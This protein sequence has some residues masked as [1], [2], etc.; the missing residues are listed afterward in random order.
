MKVYFAT[1]LVDETLGRSLTKKRANT[2]LVSYH[3][4]K[5][6]KVTDEELIQYVKIG[7]VSRKKQRDEKSC[8]QKK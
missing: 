8:D 5:E 1:W 4:I 3:F 7:R 2:R 6:Q